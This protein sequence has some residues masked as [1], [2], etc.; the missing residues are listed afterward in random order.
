MKVLLISPFYP[1]TFWSLR[2]AVRFSPAKASFPPLGLLT[3]AAML[4]ADWPKKLVDLNVEPLTDAHLDWAE[5]AFVSAMTIQAASADE[6][7][8]RCKQ[9]GLRVVAGGPHYSRELDHCEPPDHAVLGEAEEVVPELV[10]DLL[11]GE[12]KPTYRAGE[13]PD[14]TRSPVPL[15]TLVDFT[16]YADMSIQFTRGCPFT[17]DFCDVVLFSGHRPRLKTVAQIIAE[18]DA[19]YAAGWRGEVMFVDDNFIGQPVKTKELLRAVVE[20]QRAH[21]YPFWF[22]TQ[23]S[24]NL[25]GDR[26][27]LS[28]MSQAD[29]KKVFI[30]IETTSFSSL[31]EC[32]KLQNQGRD[33]VESVRAIQRSGM[34]VLAG[35][36]VGFDM[37]PP[38]VF[39]DQV[40]MIQEAGIPAAM[41][42][43]LSAPPGTPLWQRMEK[44]GRLLGLPSGDNSM[45]TNALNFVPKMGRESLVAGYK[46]MAERLYHPRAYFDRVLTFFAHYRPNGHS[47]VRLT[48]SDQL[49]S[50]LKVLWVMGVRDSGRRAFW[51]FIG[52]VALKYRHLLTET[53]IAATFG[54]HFCKI[55]RRFLEAKQGGFETV[56]PRVRASILET[57]PP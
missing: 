12:A 19:L 21:R 42:G 35:F 27:L 37:D 50:L 28:L 5:I 45:D 55:A 25:A 2:H 6:V 39:D 22:V 23:A 10:R 4:P 29:F 20:W 26:E 16:Q 46:S 24:L 43:L 54:Y 38:T 57:A 31:D 34:E 17:C 30:G 41:I 56:F 8:L 18:M 32:G 51:R 33:L 13:F 7:V 11:R 49:K 15:W 14:V 52:T 3:V 48:L 53:I 40:R 9:R 44:E 1:D 36:I 47:A